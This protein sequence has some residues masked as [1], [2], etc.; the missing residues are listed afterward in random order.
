MMCDG[1]G[2]PSA[3]AVAYTSRVSTPI[4]FRPAT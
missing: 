4:A 2:Y 1:T 3:A